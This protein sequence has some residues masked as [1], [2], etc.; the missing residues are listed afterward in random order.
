MIQLVYDTNL[1][2]DL[3]RKSVWNSNRVKKHL[4]YSTG[5]FEFR[6]KD[7]KN[8]RRIVITLSRKVMIYCKNQ[9]AIQGS[10]PSIKSLTLTSD[11]REAVWSSCKLVD[12]PLLRKDAKTLLRD[13]KTKWS[14]TG[15]NLIVL[16]N[17]TSAELEV[18]ELHWPSSLSIDAQKM[19]QV[20]GNMLLAQKLLCAMGGL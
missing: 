12:S 5:N 17:G 4:D 10:L 19:L 15:Y 1:D 20:Q 6:L 7:D 3:T 14:I 9:G 11:E 2:Y 8:I 16:K 13:T 18:P